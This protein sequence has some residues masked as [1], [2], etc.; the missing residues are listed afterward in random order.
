MRVA[1]KPNG[2]YIIEYKDAGRWTEV[3][4]TCTG[5]IE[6]MCLDYIRQLMGEDAYQAM[7]A[8]PIPDAGT[9]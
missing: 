4:G 1:K 5:G 6:S 8:L 9:T 7:K 3:Y 2:E